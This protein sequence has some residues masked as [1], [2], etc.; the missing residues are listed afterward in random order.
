MSES[1]GKLD[2]AKMHKME[3]RRTLRIVHPLSRDLIGRDFHTFCF[4]S[5]RA[6][7][8][9][10][11]QTSRSDGFYRAIKRDTMAIEMASS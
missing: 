7:F 9:L 2:E 4:C 8:P 10:L 5:L 1:I 11:K 3:N 6:V